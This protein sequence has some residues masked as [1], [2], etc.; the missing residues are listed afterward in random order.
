QLAGAISRN[1]SVNEVPRTP[2]ATG[3]SPTDSLIQQ[4]IDRVSR[5]APATQ[6]VAPT[7][8]AAPQITA[9][10]R[11][12]ANDGQSLFGQSPQT[13]A[14]FQAAY[15]AGA[16]TA[17]VQQH[18]QELLNPPQTTVTA[19]RTTPAV[20]G[21]PPADL[22]PL[23]AN[24]IAGSDPASLVTVPQPVAIGV[25]LPQPLNPPPGVDYGPPTAPAPEPPSPGAPSNIAPYIA[26]TGE[27]PSN[28]T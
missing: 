26:A 9:A 1:Q 5:M 6:I 16:A 8:T 2:V 12:V 13:I 17:W 27:K 24:P 3:A 21:Q 11:L 22:P 4:L 20:P 7:Q 28:D 23:T 25:N 19:Y 10:P 14:N 15:G 18:E